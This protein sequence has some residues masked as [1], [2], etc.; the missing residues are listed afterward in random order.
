LRYKYTSYPFDFDLD[1]SLAIKKWSQDKSLLQHRYD[2]SL[3]VIPKHSSWIMQQQF[4]EFINLSHFW[5][6]LNRLRLQ[7]TL[8][9]QSI[10]LQTPSPTVFAL[11][12]FIKCLI[13]VIEKLPTLVTTQNSPAAI[14]KKLISNSC[15][16]FKLRLPHKRLCKRWNDFHWKRIDII[17]L[18][19]L[20]NFMLD[21]LCC[22]NFL[23]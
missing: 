3:G 13:L 18:M 4:L 1:D 15:Y 12:N 21:K 10:S 5:M 6:V 16:W 23:I 20:F 8:V 2:N 14:E 7:H 17:H 9:K 19:D 11:C 22:C